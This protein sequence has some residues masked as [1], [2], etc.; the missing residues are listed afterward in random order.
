MYT[1]QSA[2]AASQTQFVFPGLDIKE[3]VRVANQF[4][5]STGAEAGPY[6][7]PN[8]RADTTT[9][10]VRVQNSS[11]DLTTT[12]YNLNSTFLNVKSDT[13]AY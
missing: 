7:L 1:G 6:V 10:R 9:L 13:K 2:T 5:V 11:T 12:V 4:V 3:G 8:D